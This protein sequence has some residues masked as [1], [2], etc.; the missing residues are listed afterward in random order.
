MR[1]RIRRFGERQ[2]TQR[3]LAL[4]PLLAVRAGNDSALCHDPNRFTA[5][6][7]PGSIPSGE[8][9]LLCSFHELPAPGTFTLRPFPGDTCDLTG[10]MASADPCRLSPVSQPGFSAGLAIHRPMPWRQVSPDKKHRRSP[11][12]R[13]DM[14]PR[15]LM[16]WTSWFV[17]H[18]SELRPPLG[19]V[20]FGSRH[21]LRLPPDPASRRRA[22]PWLRWVPSTPGK[23][24]H[25]P[26]QRPC[27]AYTRRWRPVGRHRCI[28]FETRARA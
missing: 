10:T 21:C 13:P 16:A 19:F 5:F 11:H 26:G 12:T 8:C 14:P 22:C 4:E 17:A 20:S 24:F 18:S 9:G 27:W 7:L 23:D 28:A 1:G 3:T 25:L 6:A 15:P 2:G